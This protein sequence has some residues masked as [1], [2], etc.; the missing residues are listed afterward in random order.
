MLA[1]ALAY[2]LF[3]A[4][5]SALLVL[6]G[7]F[8]LVASPDTI[9]SLMDRLQGVM[10][11]EATQLVSDSLRN[12]EQNPASSVVMTV[13]GFLLALWATT[14]AMNAFMTAINIAYDR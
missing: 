1:S 5:P 13:V 9:T 6:V 2:S 14:G 12:L 10:P 3:F 7:V 4:I 11:S 8:T